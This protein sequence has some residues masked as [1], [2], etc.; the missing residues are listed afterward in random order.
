MEGSARGEKLRQCWH[1]GRDDSRIRLDDTC[2]V[3]TMLLISIRMI[4]KGH[5]RELRCQCAGPEEIFS[6]K[7]HNH[8]Y[9]ASERY[10]TCAIWPLLDVI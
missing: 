1:R 8:K 9:Q 4:G 3:I 7:T 2:E 10:Q 6:V 5:S